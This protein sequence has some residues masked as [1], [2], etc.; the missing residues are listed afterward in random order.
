MSLATAQCEAREGDSSQSDAWR[1]RSRWP[2][3]SIVV[4]NTNE[5][6]HLRRCLPA[7]DRQRYPQI[8]IIVVDNASTDG[9]VAWIEEHFPHVRIVRNERNLGYAGANNVGFEQARGELIAVLNPDTEVDPD[10]LAEIA[11]ALESNPRAGLA[12]P[13]IVQMD[14]PERIN[15]CGNDVT[16]TGLTF[17]RGLDQPAQ[18]YDVADAVA[19]VSGAAFVIRKQVLDEIGPFDESFFVYFEDTDL[20]LRAILAGYECLFVPRA[21]VRHK[22]LFKLSPRKC[23]FQERNRY[24][25]LLRLFRRPTLVALLPALLLSELIVWGYLLMRGPRVMWAKFTS[26]FAVLAAAGQ[27]V[28][29]RRRVQALRRVSDREIL[30]HFG[31]RLTLAQTASPWL[32][33]AAE[34]LLNPLL[35]AVATLTRLVVRW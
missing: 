21:I 12:T 34:A 4:V 8:E 24:V 35:F 3:V 6:H 28:R 26:Y 13:K 19:A 33:N 29:Q 14:R 17:C 22:Y 20:S 15:A 2:L 11:Q 27:I 30:A 25:A 7:L 31:S 32:R 10:W 1:R 16:F 23:F 18:A 5:L 9:S